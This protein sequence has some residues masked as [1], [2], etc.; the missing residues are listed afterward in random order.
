MGFSLDVVE[1]TLRTLGCYPS[2]LN[3]HWTG[4]EQQRIGVDLFGE[5]QLCSKDVSQ[6]MVSQA[7]EEPSQFADFSRS[8]AISRSSLSPSSPSSISDS[9][10]EYS[11]P[12]R[13]PTKHR[14]CRQR[15]QSSSTHRARSQEPYPATGEGRKRHQTKLACVW[16]R[17]L[18]KKCDD[19][20]PC[21]RCFQFNRCSEC[22]D[23][24]PRKPRAK[25]VERGTYKKTRDLA[26]QDFQEAIVRRTTYV[27][28]LRRSGKEVSVGLSP[29]EILKSAKKVEERMAKED[30]RR[31]VN[32]GG[33]GK[34]EAIDA[35]AL[36]T[37]QG[38]FIP[39]SGAYS[40]GGFHLQGAFV[41]FTGPL[42]DLFTCS[43]SSPD[44]DQLALSSRSPSLPAPPSPTESH[45][46]ELFDDASSSTTGP[47]L[48]PDSMPSSITSLFENDMT[49]EWKAI[50]MFPNLMKLV[51]DAQIDALGKHDPS[52][53]GEELQTRSEIAHTS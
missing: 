3:L 53:T 47:M 42:E 18:G 9:S 14:S 11:P 13:K 32:G 4:Q 26:T 25:G 34:G 6:S 17:K 1:P 51:H 8:P 2:P 29:D 50:D 24:A 46:E 45:F 40:P 39:D 28:K 48:S 49:Y 31:Q 33:F 27:G 15:S 43:A 5:Q 44:I 35:D 41:P 12:Q 21:A 37:D 38:T 30:G 7:I 16:C 36:G 52:F 10:D 23:A 19:Q 20:R 22:V